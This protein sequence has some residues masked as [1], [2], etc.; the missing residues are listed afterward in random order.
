MVSFLK[1]VDHDAELLGA[2]PPATAE[3]AVADAV[4][5]EPGPWTPPREDTRGH[6]GLLVVEG[7][8]T[9]RVRLGARVGAELLGPGD[10][11]R[12]W[13]SF[14]TGS[15]IPDT[16]GWRVEQPALLARLD[17]AFAERVERFPEVSAAI[18]DRQTRRQRW[19]SLQAALLHLPKLQPRLRLLFWFLADRWGRVTPSGILLPLPLTHELLAALSG[20]RRPA[21]TSALGELTAGGEIQRVP[22]G[23]W[24]LLGEPPAELGL[25]AAS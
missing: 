15:S 14:G 22:G 3:A 2:A 25:A 10:I 12:P 4:S 6:F 21:V 17:R 20:A 13:V 16:S 9:R 23:G 11:L 5:V 7:L 24:L 19:L 8:I 18:M 1:I